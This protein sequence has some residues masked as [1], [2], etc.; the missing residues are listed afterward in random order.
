VAGSFA[1]PGG[2]GHEG[3]DESGDELLPI[4]EAFRPGEDEAVLSGRFLWRGSNRGR[5]SRLSGERWHARRR[6]DDGT[7]MLKRMKVP[8]EVNGNR[9]FYELSD[10]N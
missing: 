7:N 5:A 4:S 10:F 3:D 8:L 9:Y 2:A 6:A 1:C